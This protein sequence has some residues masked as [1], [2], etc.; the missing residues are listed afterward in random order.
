MQNI[1][2]VTRDKIPRPKNLN[3]MEARKNIYND[4]GAEMKKMR[5]INLRNLNLR[6]E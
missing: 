2:A 5:R 6:K 4:R 3:Q 1:V